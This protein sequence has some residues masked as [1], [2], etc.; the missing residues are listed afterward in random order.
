MWSWRAHSQ[1]LFQ[2]VESSHVS[3]CLATQIDNES[4][5]QVSVPLLVLVLVTQ[6]RGDISA[7][8]SYLGEI[9][10]REY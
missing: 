7:L 4:Y 8:Y 5:R 2:A 1:R 6:K 10:S 3:N 9:I